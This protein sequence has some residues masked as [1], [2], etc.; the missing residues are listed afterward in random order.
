MAFAGVEKAWHQPTQGAFPTAL[1]R[2]WGGRLKDF[3]F[4]VGTIYS[5]IFAPIE[6][7]DWKVG[8]MRIYPKAP[9]TKI[10]CKYGPKY[11]DTNLFGPK[12]KLSSI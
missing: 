6:P 4:G 5:S 7:G 10:L 1:G 12:P 2:I 8:N 9:S 3:G 11:L